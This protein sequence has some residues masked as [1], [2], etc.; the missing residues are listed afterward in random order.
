VQLFNMVLFGTFPEGWC[1]SNL[2]PVPKPRADP[3]SLDGF[4][5]IAVGE[6]LGKL[7]SMCWGARMDTWAEGRKGTRALGQA[8]FRAGRGTSDNTFVLRHLIDA[9]ACRGQPLHVA[10][11]DFSKAYDRVDRG[12]LWRVLEGMGVHGP[13]LA[14]LRSMYAR[15]SLQVRVAGEMGEPF[16]SGVGVKQGCP[17]SPLLFGI[18]I[19]RLEPYLEACCG[20]EGAAMAGLLVRCL[21]YADDIALMATSAAGL[22]RLLDA[23]HA[24]CVANGMV[25]N[26]SKSQVV[27]FN[28][29]RPARRQRFRCGGLD[30]DVVCKYLYLGLG[31]EDASEGATKRP[32]RGAAA[33]AIEKA[34]G[35]MNGM[36]AQATRLKLHNT[37]A[38]GHLFDALVRSVACAGCEVW[39]VDSGLARACAT[40]DFGKGPAESKLVNPFWRRVWG[41]PKSTP[42]VPMLLEAGRQPMAMFC[43]RMAAQLW[44][45]ALAREGGDLLALALRESVALARGPG[46]VRSAQARLLWAHQFTACLDGLGVGWGGAQVPARLDCRALAQTATEKWLVQGRPGPGLPGEVWRA[47]PL[48]VRAAPDTFSAGF[49]GLAYQEW[50]ESPRGWVRQETPMFHLTQPRGIKAVMRLRLGAWKLAVREGRMGGGRRVPRGERLCPLC[51]NG[52][53]DELHLWECAA[54]ESV[55]AR[56]PSLCQAPA[57]GWTDRE[58]RERMNPK[59]REM[60]M[61]MSA[62]AVAMEQIRFPTVLS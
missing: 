53:E 41:L 33:A 54:Y 14:A 2:V 49:M 4:R 19:D 9:A 26:Q 55:R 24:F 25:V 28:S 51:R 44:N 11:I 43:L 45:R 60:W 29:G 21:F 31:F 48:A 36:L 35:A 58:F 23:L 8:G 39:G 38:L 6:V 32:L 42:C 10:F 57:G 62:C 52:V 59:T 61:D 5:G 1:T 27:V 37:N 47:Q 7:Y 56:Y 17:L 22:Q 3:T 34:I 16:S 18:F 12:L 40:G 30:L 50:F 20:Q 46:G 15:V 13:C